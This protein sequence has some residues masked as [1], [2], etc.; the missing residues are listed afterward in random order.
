MADIVRQRQ[1]LRQIL[2]QL[3]NA[4]QRARDL[5]HFDGVGQAVAEVVG[6]LRGEDLC[7]GLQPPESTRMHHAVAVALEGVAVGVG[8]FGIGAPAAPFN[9]KAQPRKHSVPAQLLSRQ[10]GVQP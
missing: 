2:V 5:R 4:G 10:F 3:Q 6:Q 1:R 8:G 7:F 9:R